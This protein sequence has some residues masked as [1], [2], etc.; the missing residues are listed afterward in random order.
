[1]PE[2]KNFPNNQDEYR[3]AEAVMR[4]LYGRT[5]GVFGAAGNAAVSAFQTPRMAVQVSDGTG[6]LA[7]QNGLGCVWWID[8]N[9]SGGS[10]L[11]LAIDAADAVYNRIDRVIVEWNTP[12]YTDWPVVRVLKGTFATK[13]V[14]PALTNDSTTRQIS[15]ARI[16]IKAGA[17]GISA[18]DITD[19]RLDEAV[20]GLVTDR[21]NVD[22]KTINAQIMALVNELRTKLSEVEAQTYYSSKEYVD[23]AK[24]AANTYTDTAVRKAAPRNLLDN[25]DFVNLIAQA[26]YMGT[27]GSTPYLADRWFVTGEVPSYDPDTRTITFNPDSLSIITQNV[28]CDVAGKKL[29]VAI[30]ASSV[31]GTV[32]LTDSNAQSGHAD[33]LIQ[34][35]ITVHTFVGGEGTGAR[36]YSSYGGSIVI[37]WIALY[38]GEYTADTLPEYRH[39]GYSAELRECQRYYYRLSNNDVYGTQNPGSLFNA[40]TIRTTFTLPVE[41]RVNP[42]VSILSGAIAEWNVFTIDKVVHP[43]AYTVLY[44][45]KNRAVNF[46][47]TIPSKTTQTPAVVCITSSID[48]SADL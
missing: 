41:M 31:D 22:T 19:E 24:A 34:T 26:G 14:A 28:G 16:Y 42:T 29:T 2:I 10:P 25:S 7:D 5:S 21:V 36:I 44:Q 38:E 35:G 4:W 3:G 18:A 12:N 48:F 23:T 9:A 27:H 20:C 8:N 43:T 37:D 13:A 6:W 1:M 15:L 17:T 46:V 32:F 11:A 33:V 40:T 45:L 39:K 47:L 30:K